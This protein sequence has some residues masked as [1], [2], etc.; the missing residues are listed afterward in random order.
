MHKKMFG[1]AGIRGL[2]NR[3][4]TPDLAL[5]IARAFGDRM[6]NRGRAVVGRDTR[7]GAAM[8]SLAAASGLTS[9]GFDVADCGVIP[10]GGLC[11]LLRDGKY[12]CGILITG[13]HTPYD[14]IG[15]ICLLPDGAYIPDAIAREVEQR[16]Y[17]L[18]QSRNDVGPE[19]VG[20]YGAEI[21]PLGRYHRSLVEAVDR[22][23]IAGRRFKVVVDP[24]NGTASDILPEVLRSLGCEVH[25]VHG[26]KSPVPERPSEP[27]APVLGAAR[28]RVR[29]V[30][31]QLG[32][33]TDVDA[34]RV[35]FI[36]ESGKVLSEDLIG[37][38][39]AD[40]LFRGQSG[41]IGVFPIN[42]SGVMD[43]TAARAG[44]QLIDCPPGQP[45]T[46]EVVKRH[47]A[48][49][50]CEESGKYY[51]CKRALWCDG[52]Y[53]AARML[54]IMATTGQPLSALAAP[55]P[56]FHQVK[57]TIEC[58]DAIKDQAMQRVF[59]RMQ[60]EMIEGRRKDVTLDGFKRVYED[61]SWLLIRKSGTEPLVRVYSDAMSPERAQALVRAG[62]DV[63][64]QAMKG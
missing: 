61:N 27:R 8:L 47:Q 49:F 59:E 20:H 60:H 28:A 24:V 64:R 56:T 63:L 2:T 7:F 14:R 35:L 34:D 33:C 19:R 37:A 36:D 57:H 9:A 11:T 48:D 15:V 53:A 32:C 40:H 23:R 54:E 51:F 3:E 31:A 12:D 44:F 4:I 17:T 50:A 38:L 16:Y 62:E 46:V 39:F 26:Q 10:T 22:T 58:A 5:R 18:D 29:E 30:G 43:W 21:D 13:S 41:G 6:G 42:T 52:L 45:S 1:T 25:V 55:F